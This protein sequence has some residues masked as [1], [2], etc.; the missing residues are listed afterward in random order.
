MP[1]AARCS[2]LRPMPQV[3]P[4]RH[5]DLPAILEIYNGAVL[6]T[7]ASYDLEPVTLESRQEWFGQKEAGGWPVLVAEEAGE[8]VGFATFGPF[9]G[10]AGFD[11]TAEHSVYIREGVRG[12]GL[13]TALM[14]PLIAEARRMGLHVLVGG[15][16]AENAGSLR[17]H[18]RFGFVPVAHMPHV[19]R[20]FGRWLDLVFV[21]LILDEEKSEGG[22]AP[23][24][25]AQTGAR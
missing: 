11:G 15:I 12:G 13:G 20:K 5:D 18:G 9:R 6:H 21:Q 24:G 3:R 14:A 16:D 19:G 17:F 1:G 25:P 7:T 10:K 23:Y 2:T 22:A 8:V 4:A